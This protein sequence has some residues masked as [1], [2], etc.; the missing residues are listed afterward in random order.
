MIVLP[1]P[2]YQKALLA[3]KSVL[4]SGTVQLD[5]NAKLL[6][7]TNRRKTFNWRMTL[8]GEKTFIGLPSTPVGQTLV[9]GLTPLTTVGFQVSIT[10]HKQPPGP[11]SQTISILVR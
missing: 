9:S 5:A 1:T 8:D 10:L 11:W 2:A 6:D 7:G 3:A 4:P